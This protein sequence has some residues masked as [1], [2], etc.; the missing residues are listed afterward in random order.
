MAWDSTGASL[1]PVR[2]MTRLWVLEAPWESVTLNS[3][4]S[5]TLAPAARALRAVALVGV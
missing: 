5:V 2:V 4:V 3:K 1:V